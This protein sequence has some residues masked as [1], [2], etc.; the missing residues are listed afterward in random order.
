MKSY[1]IYKKS[2]FY[3]TYYNMKITTFVI[4]SLDKNHCSLMHD[5]LNNQK[6]VFIILKFIKGD[7]YAK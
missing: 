4:R 1:T 2:I 7:K 5:K 3:L 6:L